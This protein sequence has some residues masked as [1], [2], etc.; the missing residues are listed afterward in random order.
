MNPRAA[1]FDAIADKWDGW[2]DLNLLG[3]RMSDGLTRMGVGPSETVLDIGC[4][5][6]N[7]TLALLAKLESGGR[8][9]AVD[10]SPRM[11]D[12]ARSKIGDAR[13]AWHITGAEALPIP[14]AAADR[15]ICFSVWPH[16]HDQDAVLREFTRVLRPDGRLHIWHLSPKEK[17]NQIHASSS[18]PISSDL[19]LPASETAARLGKAGFDVFEMV[20]DAEQYL[21]SARKAP[22]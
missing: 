19:L 21:V 14:S 18:G 20:D 2:D 1:F 15:V 11:L 3:R 16:L 13:V 17:I 10:I 6:G 7:L 5:T 8:V 12:V 4:G 9:V 22:K